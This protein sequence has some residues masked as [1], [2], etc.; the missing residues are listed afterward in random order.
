MY[1][2]IVLLLVV[3][4][5]LIKKLNKKKYIMAPDSGRIVTSS[6]RNI[7]MSEAGA[8]E[9]ALT[10]DEKRASANKKVLLFGCLPVSIIFIVLVI[11]ASISEYNN[12]EILQPVEQGGSL[13]PLGLTSD[14]LDALVGKKVPYNKWPVWGNPQVLDGTSNFFYAA[15]LD[16]ADIS[17]VS[18]KSTDQVLFAGF[19]RSAAT[20]YLSERQRRVEK[21][22]SAYDGSH[23]N[24]KIAVKETMNDPDSF[25]H[26]RTEYNDRG[27]HLVVKMTFRGANAFGGKVINN[28]TVMTS[29]DGDIL[30]VISQND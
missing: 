20:D 23:R 4:A 24:L 29:L 25:E 6:I 1:F 19:G 21:Q 9:L 17:F 8:N 18:N 3:I 22:F 28:I 13:N 30:E 14:S 26:V 15:Y 27:D 12:D 2:I 5:L 11:V 16:S 10:K 7:D